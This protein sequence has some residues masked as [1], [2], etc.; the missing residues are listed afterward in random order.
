MDSIKSQGRSSTN[1]ISHNIS[2]GQYY[3]ERL[4]SNIKIAIIASGFNTPAQ[5]Q[6]KP[7]RRT[8]DTREEIHRTSSGDKA[9][10]VHKEKKEKEKS[11]AN[12]RQPQLP[13][14]PKADDI[15]F[16]EPAYQNWKITGRL[17]KHK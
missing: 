6:T 2:F 3:E 13:L 1:N 9:N 7:Y 17:D 14:T 16:D 4:D 11:D 15:N 5:I 8:Q 12:H 10:M